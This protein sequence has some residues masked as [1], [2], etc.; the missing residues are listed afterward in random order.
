[1]AFTPIQY[2]LGKLGYYRGKDNYTKT[3]TFT[4][5]QL[6]NGSEPL[7]VSVDEE[8]AK[9]FNTTPE[10]YA[11]I[12]RK[13]TMYSNGIFKHYKATKNGAEEIEDSE[14]LKLLEKPNPLQSRNEWLIDELIQTSIYGSSFVYSLKALKSDEF[15]SLF[16]N[17]PSGQMKIYP[18]GKIYQQ[19]KIEDIIEKFELVDQNGK[20]TR[21]ETKDI[22]Y[23]R[24]QNPENPILGK[25]PLHA[26]QMPISN[27]RASYGL[28]NIIIDKKGAI[29]ILSG[30][31]KGEGGGIPLNNEER[32][33]I[34]N[35]YR[36]DYGN[37]EA[38]SKIII[39]N[40]P[41]NWSPISYPT[42][43]LMLFEEITS[44]L[45]AIIDVY[46]MNEYLFSKEKGSTFAN[47]L[48]GK[49]MAYQ[50]CIIPY[51]EDF[52]YKLTNFLGLDKK[53]EWLA[54]DYSHVEAMQENEEN[55]AK[56]NKTKA[57]AYRLLKETNDFKEEDLKALLGLD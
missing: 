5:N 35:Q 22:I 24:I 40:T 43:D 47:L 39:A 30:G 46:G 19:S 14:V 21:F 54:L 6:L 29:G 42:K 3:P 16:Y 36:S 13:A 31:A 52:T 41:L 7:W 26:L 57:E 48:E 23:S 27:I 28:R 53:G 38:Q 44:D 15:P 56:A 8:E 33:R 45:R 55:K 9:I 37:S 51:A 50:D 17:L 11:V 32:L 25:S 49:R 18:T 10:L 1:M 12:M 2:A 34:E 20:G 4:V